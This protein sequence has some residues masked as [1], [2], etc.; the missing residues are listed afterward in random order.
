MTSMEK[1]LGHDLGMED[2]KAPVLISFM[3]AVAAAVTLLFFGA[4]AFIISFW[5][6]YV[7]GYGPVFIITAPL[8]SGIGVL[9]GIAAYG[10][11]KSRPW[12]WGVILFSSLVFFGYIAGL[13]Y[14]MW[15]ASGAGPGFLMMLVGVLAIVV[16]VGAYL[17]EELTP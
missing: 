1:S 17:A 2:V 13:G 5:T 15:K 14:N 7:V 9:V 12:A 6:L 3:F 8:F 16:A 11:W 4:L 10:I